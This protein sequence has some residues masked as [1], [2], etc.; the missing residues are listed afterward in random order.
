MTNEELIKE[1]PGLPKE[2]KLRIAKIIDAFRKEAKRPVE[3]RAKKVPLRDEP[4]VGMWADRKDMGDNEERKQKPS[5]RS[6]RDE[7][8]FGMWKD[9]EDMKEGGSAWV[10]DLR[11]G[12][13][14]NRLKRDDSR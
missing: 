5:K 6:F 9:R 1:I 12:P 13:H 4:F 14:W 11:D 7:P 10:R 2:V 3:D 8:F